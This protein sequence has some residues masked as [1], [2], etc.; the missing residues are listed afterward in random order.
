M[1]I[2]G[3]L[4]AGGRSSRFS[5]NKIKILSRD[6]PLIIEQIVK[7]G[8]FTGE[9]I[10]ST[11]R[12]NKSYIDKALSNMKGY[13]EALN[14]SG[15]FTAPAVKTVIDCDAVS[16][17]GGIGPIAGIYTG[18]KN[19]SGNYGLVLAS[20]MPFVSY[21]LLELLTGRVP[22]SDA[23][24]IRNKKGVEAL[25]GL[26]SKKSIRIMKKS[27]AEGVY[28]ISDILKQL[29]VSWI[30]PEELAEEKIDAYNFFNINRPE[31]IKDFTKL[32][33][34]GVNGHGTHSV[35]SRKVKKWEDDF[36]RGTGKG[37]GQ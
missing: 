17:L 23:V 21:R 7:L 36:F 4:L 3:I 14:L 20:D 13:T 2:S 22:H 16:G 8:F 32:L 12:Q 27:I 28:K 37:V 9:V 26:Y 1:D 33:D 34:R 19:I 5:F 24:I 6:V 15:N 10:I 11:S 18:L 29:K 35:D 30:G 31:D 25:C